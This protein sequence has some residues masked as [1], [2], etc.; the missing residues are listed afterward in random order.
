MI[1]D[2]VQLLRNHCLMNKFNDMNCPN[3][4]TVAGRI[5]SIAQGTLAPTLINRVDKSIRDNCYTHERLRIERL[6]GDSLPME[7]CYIN[8]ALVKMGIGGRIDTNRP[9][10]S[11]SAFSLSARQ[12]E[13]MPN[14]AQLVEL[15]TLFDQRD[16]KLPRRI[17]IRGQAGVGKTTLCKKII[18]SFYY[19]KAPTGLWGSWSKTFDRILWVPLRHL[20]E[21]RHLK[22]HIHSFHDLF[23]NEF[24]S[25]TEE[26]GL[27]KHLSESLPIV[28]SRTLFLLDGLDE[29]LSDLDGGGNSLRFLTLLLDQQN[30]IITS[31]PSAAFPPGLKG[32]D[33]ELETVGFYPEQ[34]E[35]Y[36][37]MHFT[38]PEYGESGS[39]NADEMM[40]FLKQ[41]WLMRNLVRIPIQLDALCY[42]WEQWRDTSFGAVSGTMTGIYIAI[43]RKLWAKDV[44]K[45]GMRHEGLP[46]TANHVRRTG[47][48]RVAS[49]MIQF[50]EVLAFSGLHNDQ[51]EFNA[52]YQDLVLEFVGGEILPDK[53]LPQ[54]SFV[55]T[56]YSPARSV[57]Q[58][59]H[60]IHLTFQEYFAAQYFVRKWKDPEGQLQ[61]LGQR[62]GGA[63]LSSPEQYL[64]QHKY[65][66]RYEVF[67]RF[68]TGLLDAEG[69]G[70]ADH[71]IGVIEQL[72][73]DLFGSVHQRLVMRCLSEAKIDPQRQSC[74]E[75]KLGEWLLLE[76]IWKGKV[77][78]GKWLAS[79]QEEFPTPALNHALK[80]GSDSQQNALLRSLEDRTSIPRSTLE[81]HILPRLVQNSS[82]CRSAF[83]ALLRLSPLPDE[84]LDIL[85]AQLVGDNVKLRNFAADLL[86]GRSIL[87]QRV[88]DLAANYLKD[89][90]FALSELMLRIMDQRPNLP[91]SVVQHLVECFVDKG[92]PLHYTAKAILG[93]Q[94]TLPDKVLKLINAKSK[95]AIL[96]QD[97]H[98]LLWCFR[99]LKNGRCVTHELLQAISLWINSP[100]YGKSFDALVPLERSIPLPDEILWGISKGFH[101]SPGYTD[102][103]KSF[104]ENPYLFENHAAKLL[105]QHNN[106]NEEI[107]MNISAGLNS[108][109]AWPRYHAILILSQQSYISD[110]MLLQVVALQNDAEG[111]VQSMAVSTVGIQLAIPGRVRGDMRSELLKR[112][113]SMLSVV[114]GTLQTV[115]VKALCQLPELPNGFLSSIQ[116]LHTRS[117]FSF[118]NE[119][120]LLLKR[121]M[122]LSDWASLAP[123]LRYEDMDM[124]ARV[125]ALQELTRNPDTSLDQLCVGLSSQEPK[126]QAVA[127]HALARVLSLPSSAIER[128]FTI[129]YGGGSISGLAFR[130]LIKQS[131]LRDYEVERM[132]EFMLRQMPSPDLMAVIQEGHESLF[133]R[134]LK[135]KNIPRIYKG[136]LHESF[137]RHLSLCIEGSTLLVSLPEGT[138]QFEIDP[139]QHCIKIEFEALQ[140]AV[141]QGNVQVLQAYSLSVNEEWAPIFPAV[142]HT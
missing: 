19:H 119:S 81:G 4:K 125:A 135:S 15:A 61:I 112:L 80:R 128:L 53:Q 129:Y 123:I 60:F 88:F 26:G 111:F 65:T 2:P 9:H 95:E 1:R 48:K 138:R 14:T 27:A 63:S 140:E 47:S 84:V 94:T 77:R 105:M 116:A 114:S 55:R 24:F 89:G 21:V 107:V 51:V 97:L 56:S 141:L 108:A 34:V 72:P 76:T 59:Y 41:H 124:D 101:R 106:L 10:S 70:H 90:D 58:T 16:G 93:N 68:V 40:R 43:E 86:K 137:K 71:F 78:R 96:A 87:P 3:Y 103:S 130:L 11:V 30:V 122:P 102:Y 20:K 110:E 39:V 13:Q 52:E 50:L 6:S 75:E 85:L 139:L 118:Q 134:M 120:V 113:V 44:V 35:D 100:D 66:A 49:G 109:D 12:E 67:W 7:Q 131:N 132:L 62:R 33:L 64:S 32:L 92:S 98:E 127:C 31:R 104:D 8:L 79:S 25:M 82:T 23:Y 133:P 17:M 38:A 99:I 126:L 18:Y 73:L 74:L 83:Y 54:L 142:I 117:G 36:I 115:I 37:K 45:L 136:L 29:I 121:R 42:T 91:W 5:Q 22:Q 69:P 46:V 57:A 28:G